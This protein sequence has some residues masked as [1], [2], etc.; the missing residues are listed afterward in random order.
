VALAFDFKELQIR[1]IGSW[2]LFLRKIV[3]GFCS[4]MVFSGGYWLALSQAFE[5][6]TASNQKVFDLSGRYIDTHRQVSNIA[7]YREEIN[8][9]KDKLHD[10]T[11][12]L[13]LHSEASGLLGE[14][15][16]RA[17]YSGVQFVAIKPGEEQNLDFYKESLTQ[18]TVSGSY[19]S[20]G[21][22]VSSVSAMPRLVT[23]HDFSI[24]AGKTNAG[25]IM[26]LVAKSY[27]LNASGQN[28]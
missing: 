20:L 9:V 12:L 8:K 22:F 3:L 4:I 7:S 2:P 6:L 19:N 23:L 27:W 13:P 25:L 10:L 14:I 1:N 5:D 17:T 26:D 16:Q 21:G 18:F 28:K 11:A 24:K 15:S